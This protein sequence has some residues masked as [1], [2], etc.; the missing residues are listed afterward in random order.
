MLWAHS[1]RRAAGLVA[2]VSIVLALAS[3]TADAPGG[4]D[5]DAGSGGGGGTEQAATEPFE[6]TV[7]LPRSGRDVPVD[8]EVSV[9]AANGTLDKV[10]VYRGARSPEHMLSG[11][12][13]RDGSR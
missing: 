10:E 1:P 8:T 3:C 13:S 7:E 12:V 9:S 2:G 6:A 5:E 4:T 11:S